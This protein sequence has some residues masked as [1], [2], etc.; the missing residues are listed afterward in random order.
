[1]SSYKWGYKSLIWVI[2]QVIRLL[3]PLIT[4]HEPPRNHPGSP[5]FRAFW[6]QCGGSSPDPLRSPPAPAPPEFLQLGVQ[7]LRGFRV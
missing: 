1:M 7:G 5:P 3:I 6:G 2:T 4:N